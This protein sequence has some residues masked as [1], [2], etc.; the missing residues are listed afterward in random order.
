MTKQFELKSCR[1]ILSTCKL[2]YN[3]EEEFEIAISC[4]ASLGIKAL[5]DKRE[6]E[7]YTTRI[8]KGIPQKLDCQNAATLFALTILELKNNSTELVEAYQNISN[9]LGASFIITACDFQSGT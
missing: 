5:K 7:M 1:V 9:E 6:V 2:D 8:T 4:V 3:S